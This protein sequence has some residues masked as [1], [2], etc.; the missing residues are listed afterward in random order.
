M[1]LNYTKAAEDDL[2]NIFVEG[3]LEFGEVQAVKY[4]G[5]IERSLTFIE[6]NPRAVRERFEITPVVRVHPVGVHVI[7]FQTQ[8]NDDVLIIR[9]RRA[10]EDWSND[11]AGEGHSNYIA[12]AP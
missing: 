1:A 6:S 10:S 2:L 7:I 11:P 9:V 5:V 4:R 3:I 8:E 12:I